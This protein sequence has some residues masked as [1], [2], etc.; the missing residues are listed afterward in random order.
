M[1]VAVPAEFS[2]PVPIAFPPSKNV[3]VPVGI[4]LSVLVTTE[5]NVTLTPANTFAF[6][7][8]SEVDVGA[9]AIV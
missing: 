8:V 2:V 7:V 6:E 9:F 1:N 5:V 4:T 3:T